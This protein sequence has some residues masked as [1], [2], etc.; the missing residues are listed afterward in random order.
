[1]SNLVDKLSANTH[2]LAIFKPLLLGLLGV[3]AMF[4]Q[5]EANPVS[6]FWCLRPCTQASVQSASSVSH[7]RAAKLRVARARVTEHFMS[8]CFDM[9][10]PSVLPLLPSR[11]VEEID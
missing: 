9:E 2:E 6:A 1:L 7:S 10:L 8:L 5:R 3:Q 4:E 11:G